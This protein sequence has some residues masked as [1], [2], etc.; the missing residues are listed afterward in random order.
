MV[1][2]DEHALGHDA[3]FEHRCA[4][5]A[6]CQTFTS[7]LVI[8][9]LYY[10]DKETYYHFHKQTTVVKCIDPAKSLRLCRVRF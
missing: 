4:T 1:D 9:I 10:S 7:V 2:D 3:I 8:A 5:A 6:H